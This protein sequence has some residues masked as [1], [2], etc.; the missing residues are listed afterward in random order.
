M[1]LKLTFP[2]GMVLAAVAGSV[3][4]QEVE[5]ARFHHVHLNSVDLEATF[6]FYQRMLGAIE[7]SYRSLTPALYTERSFILVTQVDAPPRWEPETAIWH[8]GWGGKDGPTEYEW[9]KQRGVEFYIPLTA[10]GRFH[11]M[12]LHGPDKELVEVFTGSQNYRFNHVHLFC[13]NV[14]ETVAWYQRHLGLKPR[15]AVL[16]ASELR[17]NERGRFPGNSIQV[18]NVGMIFYSL[19]DTEATRAWFPSGP[20]TK[21]VPTDGRAIDHLGF[22][23]RRIDPVHERMKAAGV[24]IVEPPALRPDFGFR[25][26]FVRGPDGLLIEFVEEK[27][28]PEG[29]WD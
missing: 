22:S 21:L 11:Y 23:Y 6:N 16:P 14:E 27:P 15:R 13:E 5:P 9:F 4:A 20:L 18:D 8:I 10:L 17:R 7:V 26:F 24:E 1:L 12:Y 28:M 19:P 25:S 2:A 29:L 3:S